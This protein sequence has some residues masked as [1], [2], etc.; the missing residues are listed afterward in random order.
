MLFYAI[1]AI[2]SAGK[3][4]C[5]YFFDIMKKI[6]FRMDLMAKVKD[7]TKGT[8]IKLIV[9]FAMPMLLGKDRKSVV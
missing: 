4:T 7:M 2:P 5:P 8:P 3:L 1:F 9:T 6:H